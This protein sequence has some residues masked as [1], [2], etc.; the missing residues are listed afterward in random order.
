MKF[1]SRPSKQEEVSMIEPNPQDVLEALRTRR[2]LAFQRLTDAKATLERL[3]LDQ[4]AMVQRIQSGERGVSTTLEAVVTEAHRQRQ[5]VES[6]V[7]ELGQIEDELG[8]AVEADRERERM[9]RAAEW[10]NALADLI[11]AYEHVAGPA[12]RLWA[13]ADQ[14]G[15]G[16]D[17]GDWKHLPERGGWIRLGGTVTKIGGSHG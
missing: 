11:A 3:E 12:Q 10:Q 1:F 4:T 13:L 14:R 2:K 5:E 6:L 8:R 9:A 7:E 16:L 17:N 15:I